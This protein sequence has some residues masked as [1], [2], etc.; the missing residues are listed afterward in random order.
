MVIAFFSLQVFYGYVIHKGEIMN[1]SS[2]NFGNSVHFG[3]F[4]RGVAKEIIDRRGDGDISRNTILYQANNRYVDIGKDALGWRLYPAK[5]K[6][7]ACRYLSMGG[8]YENLEDACT[9]ANRLNN[10]AYAQ[11]IMDAGAL[12]MT[13]SKFLN[14]FTTNA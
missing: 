10:N 12:E 3:Q 1:I 9:E 2:A 7:D 8:T 13:E 6:E 5:G 11:E 4:R 14:R